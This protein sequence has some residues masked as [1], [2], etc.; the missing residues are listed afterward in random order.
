MGMRGHLR[1]I[2]PAELS[3][4]QRNPKDVKKLVQGKTRGNRLRLM[5]TMIRLQKV[6]AEAR[7]MSLSPEEQ[8]KVRAGIVKELQAA[9][10]NLEGGADQNGLNLEKSW[11]VLHYLLTGKP[12]DAPPP[13]GNA[14]LGGKEIGPDLGYGPVRFLDP[15]EVREV[16]SAL[17]TITSEDLARRFDLQAMIAANIYPV[18][19]ESE[20]QMAQEYFQHLARYYSEAVAAG[21]AMLLYVI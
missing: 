4:I 11:H 18:R 17:S 13:L 15:D 7:A 16:A 3:D 21:N 8:E 9:G 6:A 19:D 1:Q 14:I 20:L 2:T 12:E 5:T 10:L